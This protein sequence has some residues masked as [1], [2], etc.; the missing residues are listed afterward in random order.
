MIKDIEDVK[1]NQVRGY[2]EVYIDGKFFCT[3]DSYSEAV[4]EIY[5]V[6]GKS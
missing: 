4:K 6:Y 3:S 2:W 5:E 1:I